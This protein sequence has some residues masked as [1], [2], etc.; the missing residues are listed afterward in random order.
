MV[1]AL[2]NRHYNRRTTF[3]GLGT[4][5]GMHSRGLF[6]GPTRQRKR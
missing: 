1:Q 4:F 2:R 5:H 3:T 6:L